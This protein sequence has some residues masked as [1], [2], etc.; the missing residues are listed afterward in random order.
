MSE[1]HEYRT[2]VILQV[3]FDKTINMGK[4]TFISSKVSILNNSK[5]HKE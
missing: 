5:L 3:I 1:V 4:F 2:D